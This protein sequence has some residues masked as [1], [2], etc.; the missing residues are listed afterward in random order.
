V[1]ISPEARNIHDAIHRPH[2]TQKEGRLKCGY[3]DPSE[4]GEQIT[5]FRSYRDNVQS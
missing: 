4:K 3:F 2:E 5:H 1:D